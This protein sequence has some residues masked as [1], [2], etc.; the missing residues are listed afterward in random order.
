MSIKNGYHEF[1]NIK[2]ATNNIQHSLLMGWSA[3][4]PLIAFSC[5]AH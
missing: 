5:I 4:L 2:I 3:N 1:I